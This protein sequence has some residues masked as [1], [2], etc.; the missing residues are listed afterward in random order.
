MDN[1]N[2]EMKIYL[3][4]KNGNCIKYI[5]NPSE[6]VQ[7]AAVKQDGY[8]IEYIE[9][10]SEAVQIASIYP[11]PDSF[12]YINNPTEGTKLALMDVDAFS[13][14]Y[15]DNPSEAVQ[16]KAVKKVPSTIKFIKNPSEEVQ[17]ES[18]KQDGNCI[19]YIDK[20]SEAVQLAAVKQK[21]DNILRIKNPSKKILFYALKQD[22][23]LVHFLSGEQ[24]KIGIDFVRKLEKEEN[25]QM[26]E[27][28]IKEEKAVVTNKTDNEI[29]LNNSTVLHRNVVNQFFG[30][31]AFNNLQVGQE[32]EIGDY[33]EPTSE[34]IKDY[35][36]NDNFW[37]WFS[38]SKVVDEEGKPIICY[39]GGPK[40]I[41]VFDKGHSGFNTAN[42]ETE[43][44]FFT[45]DEGVAE[46]YSIEAQARIGDNGMWNNGLEMDYSYDDYMEQ[47]RDM[48]RRNVHTNP[49]FISMENPIIWDN[50]YNDYSYKLIYTLT[51]IAQ[52][53][54]DYNSDFWD[55][56]VEEEILDRYTTT[57]EDGDI[58]YS[59]L[60]NTTFDGVIIKN[61]H[62]S[63][64]NEGSS[65]VFTTE[66]LVWNPNQIKSVYNKG[67][68]NL[69][70]DDVMEN[71]TL[72]EDLSST[73][74][75]RRKI[76]TF[77]NR[78]EEQ[79]RDGLKKVLNKTQKG[80]FFDYYDKGYSL[81]KL[82]KKYKIE[83]EKI[84]QFIII[85]R[86]K[87]SKYDPDKPKNPNID[88]TTGRFVKGATA[89]NKGK[90]GFMG[91]NKTSFTKADVKPAAI[92]VPK[93]GHG[94]LVTASDET[95]PTKSY[96]GK[97]YNNHKRV[98]YPRWIL[99]QQGIEVPDDCV[100]W[101][102]DGDYTNNNLDNLEV[103]TRREAALRTVEMRKK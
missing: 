59:E 6:E 100:V 18:V 82:V 62:D 39:H 98:S 21:P 57:N 65:N 20:P 89:W 74:L 30:D 13:I 3:V 50:N 92:G 19:K 40:A 55:S 76:P 49:C 31:K 53:K 44:F 77:V 17:M 26:S 45:S 43:V 8:A 27:S 86:K 64:S 14:K 102:K 78:T 46:D 80:V 91:A 75:K 12:L 5:D 38:N 88:P 63:I 23:F 32:V 16:L 54:W 87:I 1:L 33:H 96:N 37:K 81:D 97:I 93:Q 47:I 73:S 52:G 103:I 61:I 7:L 67:I 99:K 66:Y 56:R 71:T 2:E 11:N 34:N 29:E 83:P 25:E 48:A 41:K 42:N 9:N 94:H 70:N 10:P 72:T 24:G 79:T 84:K 69:Y 60:E 68:W 51:S 4:K 90:Y 36:L 22:R 101:H 35:K 95:R 15:I 28:V 58:D 85:L